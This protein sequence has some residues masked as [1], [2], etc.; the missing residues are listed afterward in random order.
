MGGR[1]VFKFGVLGRCVDQ[2]L[3][4]APDIAQ[5]ASRRLAPG[6]KVRFFPNAVDTARFPMVTPEE[7]AAA[8]EE[9]GISPQSRVLL[10]LGWDWHRKGGDL[11]LGAVRL[12]SNGLSPVVALTVGGGAEARLL[13]DRLGLADVVRVLDPTPRITELYAASDVFVTPSRAEGMPYAIAEALARGTPVVASDIPGQR[14]IVDG[15][16]ACRLTRLEESSVADGLLSLL[17]RTPLEVAAQ[18]REA[19]AAIVEKM[20]L[21]PWT[22]RLMELYER[23]LADRR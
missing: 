1:H 13:A 20:D 3:C 2:L 19:R 10:H 18:A 9:L 5:A 4:V 7:R 14:A 23:L 22:E 8:R 15:L 17:D 21:Q 16:G 11:F 12:V 6:A